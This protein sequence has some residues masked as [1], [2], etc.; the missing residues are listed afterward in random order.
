M[1]FQGGRDDCEIAAGA[2]T[3]RQGGLGL[4]EQEP[5]DDAAIGASLIQASPDDASIV[6][7]SEV[8][9]SSSA[10]RC[11]RCNC[12][13]C[14]CSSSIEGVACLRD[15]VTQACAGAPDDGDDDCGQT[16]IVTGCYLASCKP[17]C[18]P[19]PQICSLLFCMFVSIRGSGLQDAVLD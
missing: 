9:A 18:W 6:S 1:G 13:V 10:A 8:T 11:S 19:A 7:V 16:C 17:E 15:A 5:Q 3:P 12:S 2:E 14:S 4:T